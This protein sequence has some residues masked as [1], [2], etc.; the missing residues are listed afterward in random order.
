MDLALEDQEYISVPDDECLAGAEA[1]EN[2]CGT[3]ISSCYL[4]ECPTLSWKLLVGTKA[5]VNFITLHRLSCDH[6]QAP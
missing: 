4:W 2:Y 6:N 1:R 5:W 3:A